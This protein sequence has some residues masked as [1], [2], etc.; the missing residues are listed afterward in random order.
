MVNYNNNVI[1][2][3]IAK[4]NNNTNDNDFYIGSTSI[5]LNE[6]FYRHRS[7]CRNSADRHYNMPVYQFIRE[8]GD[9]DNWIIEKVE[10]YPCETK[11]QA[12]QRERYYIEE[13]KPSL[14]R[15]IP[16]RTA[17]ERYYL[18]RDAILQRKRELYLIKKNLN[19]NK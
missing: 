13:L 12:E 10:E 6:R 3:I 8:N 14:N 5:G 9:I 2:K 18:N 7:M 11:L 15:I 19:I 1:Y 16:L 4:E 17:K